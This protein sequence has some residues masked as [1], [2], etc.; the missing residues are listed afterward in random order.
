LAHQRCDSD[1]AQGDMPDTSI[2]HFRNTRACSVRCGTAQCIRC[3]GRA[4]R[5]IGVTHGPRE[6]CMYRA[7]PYHSYHACHVSNNPRSGGAGEIGRW[8]DLPPRSAPRGRRPAPLVARQH[9]AVRW[10]CRRRTDGGP[11][12]SAPGA[13]S[14]CSDNCATPALDV[15]TRRRAPRGSCFAASRVR[16]MCRRARQVLLSS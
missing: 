6:V 9:G 7:F 2:F 13:E 5:R 1:T 12:V 8:P 14:C 3:I 16:S 4:S 11:D 15:Q 10:I